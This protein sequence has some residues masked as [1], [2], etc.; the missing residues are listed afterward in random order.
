MAVLLGLRCGK[1]SSFA[2]G[3][4]LASLPGLGS[5]YLLSFSPPS[6]GALFYWWL[7]GF[8][9]KST[10]WCRI[11]AENFGWN[12]TQCVSETWST[13]CA[14]DRWAC[15]IEVHVSSWEILHPVR[16]VFSLKFEPAI[17]GRV[18]PLWADCYYVTIV[19]GTTSW[20]ISYFDC[21]CWL[22]T[23]HNKD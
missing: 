15:C 22:W 3:G 10:W 12:L 13:M 9:Q 16:E 17:K 14:Y 7:A 1:D 4:F 11:W 18:I 20:N 2:F 6:L 19:W 23:C 5:F 21:C 8:H